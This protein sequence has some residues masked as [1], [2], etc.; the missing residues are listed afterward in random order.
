MYDGNEPENHWP[1]DLYK[2]SE[3]KHT[4]FTTT[5][6]PKARRA[7]LF[8][9]YKSKQKNE[10]EDNNEDWRLKENSLYHE[11]SRAEQSQQMQPRPEI[12]IKTKLNPTA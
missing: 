2:R 10:E 4:Q 1:A 6:K 3:K 7:L 9:L 11:Q 12:K 8:A 5:I